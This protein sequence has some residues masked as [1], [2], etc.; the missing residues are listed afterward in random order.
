MF[1]ALLLPDK[2]RD[3]IFWGTLEDNYVFCNGETYCRVFP[4]IPM[5]IYVIKTN[6]LSYPLT[7]SCDS[8]CILEH[9][10]MQRT[11]V[12]QDIVFRVVRGCLVRRSSAWNLHS[13]SSPEADF[14]VS[15]GTSL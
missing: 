7:Y 10:V 1:L 3:I 5:E 11:V 8:V 4:F 13:G 15:E 2:K 12:C 6:T 9:T 14:L